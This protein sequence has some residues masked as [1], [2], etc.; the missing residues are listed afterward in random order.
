MRV[1]MINSV[2]GVGSTG[3]IC[4]DLAR[5]LEAEGHEVRIAYGRGEV[6]APLRKYGVRIG[7]AA[8]IAL[9]G[10]KARLFDASGFGSR[11][12]TRRFLNWVRQYD[13]DVIH[14][15]N[16]HGYYIHTGLL[17]RYLK[18]CGKRIIWTLH[19]CWPF[20]GHSA[21]CD[22]ISCEKWRSGCGDCPGLRL[23]PASLTDG[24]ARNWKRKRSAYTEVPNL[25]LVTPSHWL[26]EKTRSSFLSAY[27][28]QVI[29]NG[30]DTACFFPRTAEGR[31]DGAGRQDFI[32]LGV[33]G[34]WDPMKGLDDFLRLADLLGPSYRLVLVG[35]TAAQRKQFAAKLTGIQHTNS[36]RE[37][38]ELYASAEVFV[39]L[40]RC[41][42][43]P[44]VNLEAIACGTPVVCYDTGGSA[45][46][47][48]YGS[49][50]AVPFGDLEGIADAIRAFRRGELTFSAEPDLEQIDRKHCAGEYLKL[51]AAAP[52]A[53]QLRRQ[54][55][56]RRTTGEAL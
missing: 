29:H 17:F 24:S 45:E 36:P 40:S 15:H 23:Y 48:A 20:S 10:A 1:L 51:Y 2:C 26:A 39:N 14:L 54:P 19:D 27:P 38:A 25:T 30:I 3:R 4:T 47:L 22:G 31:R 44:T 46:T 6:P 18:D 9:H 49:G 55:D 8:G 37:L 12:A 34:T 5:L 7:S 32:V 16:L 21:L 28:V 33:S 42:T 52:P 13:P 35:L 41:E 11:A 50:L 53:A 43:Y 56:G